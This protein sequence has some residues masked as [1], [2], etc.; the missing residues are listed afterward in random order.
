[1]LVECGAVFFNENVI[2]AKTHFSYLNGFFWFVSTKRNK[3]IAKSETTPRSSMML[4]EEPQLVAFL[5]FCALL[6]IV[7]LFYELQKSEKSRVF[8]V[9]MSS[10]LLG[11]ISQFITNVVYDL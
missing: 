3:L 5:S 7:T 10:K 2:C 1:M 4:L 9:Q 11:I 6:L 8:D